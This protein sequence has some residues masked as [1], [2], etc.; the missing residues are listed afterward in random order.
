[1]KSAIQKGLID[2]DGKMPLDFMGSYVLAIAFDLAPERKK[3]SIAGHLIRKIEENGDCLDT[4]FLT[5]P[6]LLDALCKI[7]RMDKAYKILLQ[8]KCPSWLYEVK[9]GATTIWENYI[10]YKEDGSPVMTSLN[11]YAFGCVDDWMFRK[12]SGIDMAAPGF[13]KIVIAPEP[14]NAFTSVKRTYVSEYGEIAVRWSMEEGRFKLKVKIPCNT[15]AVVKMPDGRLYKVG[16]GMY[17][18]E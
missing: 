6:Y 11:H 4:G 1:M 9:Q 15:T 14:D 7:G 12:I 3:E 10:S 13:K 5:T 8:T 2:D 17:Q 16:S 18:F